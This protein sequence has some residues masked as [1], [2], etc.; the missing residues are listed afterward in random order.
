MYRSILL[1]TAATALSLSSSAFAQLAGGSSG[2]VETV[3]VTAQKLAEARSGIQTQLGASTYTITAEDIDNEPGGENTLLNQVILQAPGVAQD[4]FGQL[5]VRGEH[6]G[7]QYRLNGIIL[8]EG[9]SVFG[10]T[11]D[12]R[13][14]DSVKLI[15]GALPAEYGDR[16]AGVID[17]QTKSGLFEPGGQVG[18]YGGSHSTLTPS[19]D[20][21]GS[22]GGFNYFVSGDFTTSTLGIE[23][24]DGKSDPLHD[25]TDQYHGFAFLQDILDQDSSVTAILGTSRDAFQIPNQAGLQPSGIDGIVGLGPVDAGSGDNVLE[26]NGQTTFPSAGLDER[27]REITHYAIFSYLRSMGAIDM[28]VSVFGRYSSLDFTPGS[29]IGDILYD[30][31]AQTAF[32]RDEA[33]GGQAEGAWHLGDSH[34]IRFGGVYQADDL[35]SR[36]SSLVLPTAPGGLG[37]PNPNPLCTDPTNTCQTSDT[38]VPIADNGTKHAWSYGLY[39]QDEWKVFP[40]LTLN[41]GLRYDAFQAFDAENQ[42]S[43]RINAVWTPTDTTTIHAGYSRYFSP[44]PFELVASTDIA[45]FDNTTVAAGHTDDTPKAE[46]ADYLDVGVNQILGGGLAAGLDAFYK[47]SHN[48]IDEGQF[49]APIILTPFNYL[50]GRQY[51]LEFTGTYDSDNFSSY[52]N[53]SYERAT[54]QDIVS[55]QFQFD[56]GDLAYIADHYIP[57]DH[58][59][60]VTI[61]AGAS[62][63][64]RKMRF[65]MDVLYG[66]GLRKDSAIPNGDHVPGYTQVNVGVSRPLNF[67]GTEGL[68]ARFDVINLFDQTYE[69]RDG[70]GVGVGAPQFGPR[71]GFFFG[72]SKAL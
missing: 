12:P 26:A 14:A 33:W 20:Y 32:K 61:S 22:S 44:P 8:P 11:L 71:R 24:P 3:V 62:Y 15:T 57:L 37:N 36:T 72:L 70:T 7:L 52:V 66:S 47:K 29:N 67:L 63:A 56:P 30:G 42:L 64:W 25:R 31:I 43:P 50:T 41:Y 46:R 60:I 68:T 34:T 28:Q 38:P 45:L 19:F 13:L 58:E 6:N 17:V 2:S 55:S 9:I 48:M 65:S 40:A 18:V 23:S 35:T 69:I 53:A 49:G 16:T 51:G 10:Q 4:S 27:Q 39:I 59:Q 1:T 5:H 21:G 54:G